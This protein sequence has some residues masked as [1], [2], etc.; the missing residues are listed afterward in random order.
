M[1]PVEMWRE[2]GL[3]GFLC[4]ESEVVILRLGVIKEVVKEVEGVALL[5]GEGLIEGVEVDENVHI[6]SIL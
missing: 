5:A 4:S 2:G 6:Q 1:V 3:E